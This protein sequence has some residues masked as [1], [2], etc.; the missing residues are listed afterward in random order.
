[1]TFV[2]TYNRGRPDAFAA[3]FDDDVQA[4]PHR[5]RAAIR[6]EYDELFERSAWRRMQLARVTWKRQGGVAH[7]KFEADVQTGWRDGR[8]GKE[9]LA[10]DM[11]LARRDGRV[12]IIR[13]GP[14]AG[15]P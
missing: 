12:V 9:H 14:K 5:G 11:E 10:L 8:E 3:L 1:V 7:V 15:S 2:D 6:R 13:L 4:D